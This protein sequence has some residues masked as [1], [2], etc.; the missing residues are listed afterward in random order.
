MK[1]P[2]VWLCGLKRLKKISEYVPGFWLGALDV[3][4]KVNTSINIKCGIYLQS[5]RLSHRVLP[6]SR[7]PCRFEHH[8]TE[9]LSRGSSPLFSSTPLLLS[10]S[11]PP[12]RFH[13]HPPAIPT[14]SIRPQRAT[15]ALCCWVTR[16]SHF[17]HKC[18]TD[19]SAK[20]FPD[21]SNPCS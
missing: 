16:S 15:L 11:F 13:I 8:S 1:T 17:R 2:G 5:F 20:M 12:S 9:G 21:V 7:N 3:A 14:S 10:A 18:V 19:F 6:L 4:S